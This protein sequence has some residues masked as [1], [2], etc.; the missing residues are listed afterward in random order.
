MDLRAQDP[1]TL[2]TARLL[3]RPLTRADADAIAEGL[4]DWEVIRWLTAPPWPYARTDAEWFIGEAEAGRIRPPYAITKGGA[5][6]GVVAI[7]GEL[8]YWLG[9][10][11]WGQGIACE[12]AAALIAH[13]F[14]TTGAASIASGHLA[15]NARSGRVLRKLGFVETGPR[16]RFSRPLGREVDSVAMRLDRADWRAPAAP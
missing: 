1:L 15:G 5:F 7:G 2:R 14:E 6:L 9:R 13:H 16:R 3:L 8:G 11:H 10:A 4:Q 12:A